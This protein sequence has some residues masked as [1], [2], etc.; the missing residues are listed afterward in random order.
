MNIR[1]YVYMKN[2]FAKIV[3]V[4]V[5]LSLFGG[6]VQQVLTGKDNYGEAL[7]VPEEDA[8]NVTSL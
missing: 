3:L 7:F 2:L 5:L 1:R 6:C 8:D 4:S